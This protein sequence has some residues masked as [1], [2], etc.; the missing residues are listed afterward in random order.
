[1]GFW[2]FLKV[3]LMGLADL[4][5]VEFK[6]SGRSDEVLS[7]TCWRSSVDASVFRRLWISEALLECFYLGYVG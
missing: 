1:M 3:E 2:Y 7:H 4:L 6:Y 5:D